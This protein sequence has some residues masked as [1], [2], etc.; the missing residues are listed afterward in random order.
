[1]FLYEGWNPLSLWNGR[2]KAI[3]SSQESFRGGWDSRVERLKQL[4]VV[5]THLWQ[6]MESQG[7]PDFSK[8]GGIGNFSALNFVQW[9]D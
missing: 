7:F 2:S 9:I 3:A 5:T 1:M 6:E 8:S 4:S